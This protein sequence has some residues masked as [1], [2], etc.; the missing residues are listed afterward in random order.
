MTYAWLNDDVYLCI[1]YQTV[2]QGLTGEVKFDNRGYRTNFNIDVIELTSSGV[3]KVGT[4]DTTRGLNI[5][6]PPVVE[7]LSGSLK[8]K[9]FIVIITVV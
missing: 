8:N 7:D 5:T 9:T 3:V 1:S 4:W 2:V 6:R